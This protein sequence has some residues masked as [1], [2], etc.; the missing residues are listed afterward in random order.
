[1]LRPHLRH[2]LAVALAC[3]SVL[4]LPT[5]AHGTNF[6]PAKGQLYADNGNHSYYYDAGHTSEARAAT[7]WSIN[8]SYQT[9]NMY[10]YGTTTDIHGSNDLWFTVDPID[11]SLAGQTSCRALQDAD[12][13]E[14]WHIIYQETGAGAFDAKSTALQR[15][16]ACHEMGH[17]VGLADGSTGSIV[18]CMLFFNYE[19]SLPG[20]AQRR[21]INSRYPQADHSWVLR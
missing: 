15:N 7:D 3:L 5:V 4:L 13:C 21:P 11:P 14:H 17:S 10:F 8:T 9:T 2:N 18:R 19:G 20:A 6:G 12:E 1:M 16:T